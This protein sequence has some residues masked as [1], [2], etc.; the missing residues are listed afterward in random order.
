[1]K[2]LTRVIFIPLLL[3]P[4]AGC[5]GGGP[6]KQVVGIKAVSDGGY[7]QQDVKCCPSSGSNGVCPNPVT[8]PPQELRVQISNDLPFEEPEF[9]TA[10]TVRLESCEAEFFPKFGSPPVLNGSQYVTCSPVSIAPGETQE[11][12]I[13]LESSLVSLMRS[14]VESGD[15]SLPL[16]YTLKITLH[17]SSYDGNTYDVP[18]SV[19]IDFDDFVYSDDDACEETGT[20]E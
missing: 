2:S 3:L 1:M 20:N 13:S 17:F 7:V 11:V 9:G 14:R 12:I 5:G 6:S 16:S 15:Y 4:F 19:D 18:L 10:E 8:A